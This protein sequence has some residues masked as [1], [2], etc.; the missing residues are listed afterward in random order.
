MVAFGRSGWGVGERPPNAANSYHPLAMSDDTKPPAKPYP[1][2]SRYAMFMSLVSIILISRM[3]RND[4]GPLF[5]SALAVGGVLVIVP[6]IGWAVT[7]RMTR[8]AAD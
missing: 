3:L 1:W 2:F 8:R 6:I 7:K 5:W 4:T